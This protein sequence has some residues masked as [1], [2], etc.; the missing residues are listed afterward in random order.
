MEARESHAQIRWILSQG[1]GS[2]AKGGSQV[3]LLSGEAGEASRT[4]PSA[5]CG[6]ALLTAR[7]DAVQFPVSGFL[8]AA[9]L[10]ER[11]QLHATQERPAPSRSGNRP[12][13]Q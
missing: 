3:N 12:F 13:R 9:H 8:P 5:S 4:P 1:V 10:L 6:V 11:Y 7:Q 2:L